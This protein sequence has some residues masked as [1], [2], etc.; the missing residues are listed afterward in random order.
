VAEGVVDGL[1]A[2]QVEKEHGD[3]AAV[4]DGMGEGLIETVLEQRAVG[5]P[6]QGVVLGEVGNA[7]FGSLALGDVRKNRHIVGGPFERVAYRADR[8]G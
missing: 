5:Q 3:P 1:E 4:A 2:V 7:R 8:Q 6:G